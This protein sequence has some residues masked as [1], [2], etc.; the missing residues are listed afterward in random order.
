[1][2]AHVCYSILTSILAATAFLL[3]WSSEF[4]C[5]FISFTSN[6]GFTQPVTVKFGIWS[7]QFWTVA[8]SVGGSVVFETC[9]R[10]P[11][12]VDIDSTWRASRAFST[13]AL[14][15]GGIF[16]FYNLISACVSPLRKTPPV[17]AL[18]YLLACFFQ[19]MSLLILS[20]SI[21]TDNSLLEKLEL[22]AAQ[23][24]ITGLDFPETCSMS[25][26]ANCTIAAI[27]FWALSAWTSTMTVRFEKKEAESNDVIEPLIP[28]ENLSETLW[29]SREV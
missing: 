21:C 8:T 1:M 7:Y 24:G 27:I 5:A 13:L 23:L 2:G 15:L 16:L 3:C 10:Y 17:E 28:G 12:S 22:Q 19:A 20:S 9:Q 29:S 6:S 11:S 25:T 4:G 14:I 18:A 26:G